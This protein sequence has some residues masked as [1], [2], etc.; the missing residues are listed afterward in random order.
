MLKKLSFI[1]CLLLIV[2]ACQNKPQTTTKN[3]NK[4][5]YTTF[6][7]VTDLTQ[8]IVGDKMEIKTIIKGNQEPHSFELTPKEMAKLSEADL[9]VYNG[10]NMEGFIPDLMDK[11]KDENKFLNLSQGLTLLESGD[12]LDGK[13]RNVNPHTWLSIKNVLIQLDTIYQKIV[14]IDP[15]NEAY[16]K[17]NFEKSLKEFSALEN[18][19][20]QQLNKVQKTDKY[21]VVAHAAFNYLAHDYG[22]KQIAVSGISPED[23]PSAQQLKKIADFVKDKGI[24]TIFFDGKATPKVAE[25]L[26]KNTNTKTSTLY[27]MESLTDEEIK[28]GYIGIMR[29]NL[30]ALIESFNE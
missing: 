21:F 29:H 8:R 2:V 30:K 1:L 27:T 19:F 5:I 13:T 6:F 3:K 11:L 20:K 15:Q 12:S 7:P 24:T 14:S 23:E 16:Y 17:A 10:A 25:T 9:I 22:L 28:L 4:V 26:S 18:D